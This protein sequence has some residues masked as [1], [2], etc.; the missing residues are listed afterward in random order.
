MTEEEAK[1][2]WCPF[3][4][5]VFLARNECSGNRFISGDSNGNNVEIVKNAPS[6]RCI[7][8]ECMAWRVCENR[9]SSISHGY[10][11]LAGK[12]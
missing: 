5:S 9:L 3:A 2:K 8:S 1:T 10:C 6:C 4:R 11:G 7:G 12:P